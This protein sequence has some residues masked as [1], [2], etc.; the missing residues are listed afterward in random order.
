M[1]PNLL[2]VVLPPNGRLPLPI[3]AVVEVD[4][5]VAAVL[6]ANADSF[7]ISLASAIFPRRDIQPAFESAAEGVDGIKTALGRHIADGQG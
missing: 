4:I 1:R 6:V 2:K 7:R 3:A 5:K